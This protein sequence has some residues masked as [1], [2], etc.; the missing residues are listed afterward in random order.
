[1]TISRQ[2]DHQNAVDFVSTQFKLKFIYHSLSPSLSLSLYIYIWH[3]N[4]I[5]ITTSIWILCNQ[6]KKIK[7]SKQ[8][9]MVKMIR[10]S[11]TSNVASIDDELTLSDS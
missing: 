1:M 4:I 3:W 9:K 2:C 8:R 7:F 6:Y 5:Y 11:L 10:I